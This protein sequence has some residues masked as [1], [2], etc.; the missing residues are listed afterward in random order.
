MAWHYRDFRWHFPRQPV[1]SGSAGKLTSAMS[2]SFCNVALPVPL[3]KTFTYEIP[4]GMRASVEI[5]C[6]VLVPFRR[7]SLIGVVVE[8]AENAPADTKLREI[9]RVVDVIPALTPKLLELGQWIANY[10][11]APIGE[12]FRS[13]LPPTTEFAS[14]REIVVTAAGHSRQEEFK[15]NFLLAEDSGEEGRALAE[16]CKREKPFP[17]VN[18]AKSGISAEL[19]Q[20]L[21]RRGLVEIGE[22]TRCRKRKTQRI[23]AWKGEVE[24]RRGDAQK[25]ERLRL[26]LETDRGPL[27]LPQLL[28]VAKVSRSFV[29][30][31]L[32]DGALTSW[33]EALDPA[34]DP[35]DTGYE[36]PA[37]ALNPSQESAFSAIRARF[38]LREFGVQLLH[39]VTGSGKT[40]VYLR[41]VQDA[42]ARGKTAIVLVPEI[43]LTLWLGRQCRAWFGAQFES[44]VVLH[45]A[46]SDVE[47]AQAWWRVR[48]GEARVVVSTRSAV[49]APLENIGLIIVDE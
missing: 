43:A 38:E 12:V 16:L 30:R 13:M 35:F 18:I 7:K 28:K 9:A 6:R 27:P 3:R 49:F 24:T 41:A 15:K 34:E 37:H 19:I 8:C 4:E 36:P 17:L 5:G 20:R 32:R 25:L 33:E 48:H 31:L 11:L 14:R 46:L 26:L 47:R 40:E 22:I 29:E 44:V 39:G 45:S 10:Y 23:V 2:A 21:E 42:L 1:S